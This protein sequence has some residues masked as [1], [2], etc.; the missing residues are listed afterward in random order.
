MYDRATC[1]ERIRK[2]KQDRDSVIFALDI[3]T[4]T[5]NEFENALT[6]FRMFRL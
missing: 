2:L 5:E 1:R 6:S 4:K 3:S